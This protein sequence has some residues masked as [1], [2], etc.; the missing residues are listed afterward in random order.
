[1]KHD[2]IAALLSVRLLTSECGFVELDG[3]LA[4]INKKGSMTNERAESLSGQRFLDLNGLKSI[5][6]EQVESLM[7]CGWLELN[8]LESITDEQA[9]HFEK[10]DYLTLNGVKAITDAQAESLSKL[11][12]VSLLGITSIT[13]QQAKS[14]FNIL[15]LEVSEPVQEELMFHW[16]A[17][18]YPRIGGFSL[19]PIRDLYSTNQL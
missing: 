17:M 15:S 5:T 4:D 9:A 3:L 18:P 8:S 16:L 11:Q 6:D 19:P 12:G 2:L 14:L 13:E 10:L 7:P 1:M